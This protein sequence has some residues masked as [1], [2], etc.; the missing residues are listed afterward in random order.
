MRNDFQKIESILATY[1]R[2]ERIELNVYNL[3]KCYEICKARDSDLPKH[4]IYQ[5]DRQVIEHNRTIK[6]SPHSTQ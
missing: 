6:T 3:N 5:I 1:I 4:M 2:I